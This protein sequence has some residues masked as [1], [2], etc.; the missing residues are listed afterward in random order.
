MPQLVADPVQDR[1]PQVGLKR[2]DTAGLEAVDL[3]KRSKQ[4]VLDK[5]VRVGQVAR[6]AGQAAADPAA[7]GADVSSHQA[8]EGF[9]V[10]A[11]YPL[12][13]VE[14]RIEGGR[15]L[16]VVLCGRLRVFGR[17]RVVGHM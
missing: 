17:L 14:G 5:V 11:A 9:P 2:A 15:R 1:L 8:L 6:P 12:D 4:G 16:A 3:L 10:S 7:K 13:Q